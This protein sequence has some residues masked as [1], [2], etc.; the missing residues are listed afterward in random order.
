MIV[1][2]PVE[3]TDITIVFAE[4]RGGNAFLLDTPTCDLDIRI[5]VWQGRDEVPL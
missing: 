3:Y 5:G 1:I 2:V 4:A